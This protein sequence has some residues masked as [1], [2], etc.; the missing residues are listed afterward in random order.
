[1]QAGLHQYEISNFA[2]PGEGSRHNQNY[3]VR[4]DYLGLGPSAHSHR[5]GLRWSNVRSLVTYRERIAGGVLPREGDPEHLNA[6]EKA[7]EWLFL[8][9]RRTE[10]IP[11]GVLEETGLP[12]GGLRE[13]AA[14]LARQGWIVLEGERM[15][16]DPRAYFISNSVFAELAAAI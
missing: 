15:R 3:W 4:G 12:L 13:R 2:Q 8:G 6:R 7:E 14:R 11:W 5:D 16:L 1:M 9:L 10:G